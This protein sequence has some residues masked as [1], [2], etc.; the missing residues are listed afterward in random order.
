LTI[1]PDETKEEQAI[2]EEDLGPDERGLGSEVKAGIVRRIVQVLLVTGFQAALLFIA[3]GRL[4]WG[5][6]WV[7][8]GLYLAGMAVNAVLLMRFSPETIA[9]RAEAEG[10]KGWDKI[11]GGLFGVTYF[12][13][14]PIVAGLDVRLGWSGGMVLWLHAAGAA[15]F[16][17]GFAL[18][19]WSMA[20]NAY[21]AS[22][23]RVQGDRGH[24]VCNTG[25]YRY[26]R[27][28]GYAGA[29][30]HSLVVPLILGSAW[31]LIPG[32]MGALALIVRTA[33][34]DR[35]LHKE[36]DGYEEYAMQTRYRLA[37]GIW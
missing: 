16:V 30:V 7:Y 29:I 23:V 34:E 36:L 6:A 11:V 17:V 31:A 9:R 4:D 37:P 25:P 14:I 24:T 33:L 1:S 35:T 19:I 3:A 8:V 28:P 26:V 12:A 13:G 2:V 22:V 15:A 18:L 5:W 20:S 10:M 32:G 27:H 21:F